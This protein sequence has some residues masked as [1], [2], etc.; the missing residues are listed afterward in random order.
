MTD[1]TDEK[2]ERKAPEPLCCSDCG[3]TKG[4]DGVTIYAKKCSICRDTSKKKEKPSVPKTKKSGGET[5]PLEPETKEPVLTKEPCHPDKKS[6]GEPEKVIG[7]GLISPGE[8]SRL[9]RLPQNDAITVS[10]DFTRYPK[11]HKSLLTLAEKE[12]RT[13]A[14]QLL[15]LLHDHLEGLE[16]RATDKQE[17]AADGR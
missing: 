17:G 13:P 12:F 16:E 7:G 10:V 14:N 9:M 3:R 1:K 5:K 4:E 15:Y 11:I 2:P 8:V 6:P